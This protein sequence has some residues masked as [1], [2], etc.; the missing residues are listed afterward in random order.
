[1]TT[2]AHAAGSEPLGSNDDKPMLV[3]AI[4]V[5]L[6]KPED[7]R[8]QALQHKRKFEEKYA[9]SK[10]VGEIREM[11]ANKI[12]GD[13]S[14]LAAFTGGASG[15]TGV[16]PGI[17][18]AVA[19][20]GGATADTAA[21]MKF[22]IE[23]TMSIATIYDHDITR[24]EGKNV[25]YVVAGVGAL[26]KA[27][28]EGGKKVASQAAVKMIQQYLKGSALAAIK[29][30]FKQVGITFTRKAL[31]KAAPFGIGVVLGAGINKAL[32]VYVGNQAHDYFRGVKEA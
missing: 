1:M 7:I 9:T 31:E 13:Y 25:C 20:V 2:E 23:M 19:M 16:I 6:A 8:K 28:T 22:Q 27:A 21:C 29:E 11:V 10:S 15:L 18:T 26:N 3:K 24:E 30:I 17:G 12:I 32:T 5:I 14:N 4:D